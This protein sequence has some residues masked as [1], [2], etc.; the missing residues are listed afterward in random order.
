MLKQ[1]GLKVFTYLLVTVSLIVFPLVILLTK[2][3]YLGLFMNNFTGVVR[4]LYWVR[5]SL[6]ILGSDNF[7]I[8]ARVAMLLLS[9]L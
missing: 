1:E 4:S 3:F 7:F 9:T 8:D 6:N 5:L 2:T